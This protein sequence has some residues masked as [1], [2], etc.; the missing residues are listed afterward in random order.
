MTLSEGT[1]S[2][3]EAKERREARCIWASQSM[4]HAGVEGWPHGLLGAAGLG[5]PLRSL[6]VQGRWVLGAFPGL[7]QVCQE[8]GE[9]HRKWDLG[10]ATGKGRRY[11]DPE[12]TVP[13]HHL[14]SQSSLLCHCDFS[15]HFLSV[16]VRMRKKETSRPQK[17]VWLHL[18]DMAAP[19]AWEGIFWGDLKIR[20]RYSAMVWK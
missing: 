13:F 3:E 14:R 7:H 19:S 16:S 6:T 5:P 2:A 8:W 4:Q 9:G 11:E 17:V 15:L 12:D 18:Q 20:G 10:N 1:V